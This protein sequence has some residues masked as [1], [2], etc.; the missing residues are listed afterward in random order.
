MFEESKVFEDKSRSEDKIKLKKQSFIQPPGGKFT[1]RHDSTRR[2]DATIALLMI[3]YEEYSLNDFK[4]TQA[5]K[6]KAERTTHLSW[7]KN[8]Y[9]WC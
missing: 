5:Q 8:I 4:F 7:K 3:V 2:P 6:G 1:K 9:Q